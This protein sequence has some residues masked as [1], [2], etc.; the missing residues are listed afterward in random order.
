MITIA[1]SFGELLDKITILEI[2]KAKLK[3]LDDIK[4]VTFELNL[5]NNTL[6][7]SNIQSHIISELYNEL[8]KVNLQLWEIE[9]KIR[10]KE[11]NNCFDDEF[12]GLA[13]NVYITNDKRSNIKKKINLYLKSE[14]IEVK[15]YQDY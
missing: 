6:T 10:E 12:I 7:K 11:K 1:V 8:K 2:K 15:S 13:R 14:V 4:K 9:D 5:L 3:N